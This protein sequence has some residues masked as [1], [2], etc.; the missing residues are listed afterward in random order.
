MREIVFENV[1][2]REQKY[3]GG[4]ALGKNKKIL[5]SLAALSCFH[6]RYYHTTHIHVYIILPGCVILVE[7]D[8][9]AAKT[10]VLYTPAVVGLVC[11]QTHDDFMVSK[12]CVCL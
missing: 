12:G 5:F 2:G 9:Q 4:L 11:V 8:K 1:D 10:R 3:R 7:E 6:V